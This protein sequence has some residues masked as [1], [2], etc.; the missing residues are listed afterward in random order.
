MRKGSDEDGAKGLLLGAISW[1][2]ILLGLLL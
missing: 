2:L 1:L